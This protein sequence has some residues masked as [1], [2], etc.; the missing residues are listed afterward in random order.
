MSILMYLCW[1]MM[2]RDY[3]F[4]S[5]V[6]GGRVG[7]RGVGSREKYVHVHS[8]F[9]ERNNVRGISKGPQNMHSPF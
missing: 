4:I 1:G 6:G 3:K 7:G 5:S 9:Y 8:V 2:R